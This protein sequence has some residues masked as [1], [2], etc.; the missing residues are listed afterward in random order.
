MGLFLID[1]PGIFVAMGADCAAVGDGVCPTDD[2]TNAMA[3]A[4]QASHFLTIDM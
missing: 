4:A 2:G 1:L 3:N